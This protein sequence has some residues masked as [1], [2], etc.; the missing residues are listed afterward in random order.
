MMVSCIARLEVIRMVM[1]LGDLADR[2]GLK[3]SEVERLIAVRASVWPLSHARCE[4]WWPTEFQAERAMALLEVCAGAL[5]LMGHE[6]PL[7]MR[8]RNVGLG[9][10]PI[11]FLLSRPRGILEMRDILVREVGQC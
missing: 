8:T 6:A 10:S 3:A 9:Q 11:S 2:V 1:C 7:W 5:A 4:L